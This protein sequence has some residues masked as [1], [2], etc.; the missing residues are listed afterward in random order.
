M[1]LTDPVHCI[2]LLDMTTFAFFYTGGKIISIQIVLLSR[3]TNLKKR[4]V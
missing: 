1:I 4:E 2:E 3:C